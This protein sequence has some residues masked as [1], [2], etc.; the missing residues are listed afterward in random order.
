MHAATPPPQASVR[1]WEAAHFKMEPKKNKR[2]CA[3][4]SNHH[5]EC[6][7]MT[8]WAGGGGVEVANLCLST[9]QVWKVSGVYRRG[10]QQGPA[11]VHH[12]S[13]GRL[14]QSDSWMAASV[15][16]ASIQ[17]TMKQGVLA[18]MYW[19]ASGRLL[20]VENHNTLEVMIRMWNILD[21]HYGTYVLLL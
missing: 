17:R 6:F 8:Y 11:C 20:I 14:K 2:W 9:G 21:E 15:G 19:Q 10:P 1:N 3:P 13:F 5:L 4:T 16:W 7:P 12:H 18:K